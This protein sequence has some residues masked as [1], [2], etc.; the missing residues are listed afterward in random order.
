MKD[1]KWLCNLGVWGTSSYLRRRRSPQFGLFVLK[2]RAL[3][4][5]PITLWGLE[6][7]KFRLNSDELK[8]NIVKK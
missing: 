4:Q 2:F 7:S 3:N 6:R 1:L 8:S 5:F